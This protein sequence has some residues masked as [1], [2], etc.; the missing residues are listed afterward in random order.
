MRSSSVEQEEEEEE[1]EWRWYL[2]SLANLS[3][4]ISVVV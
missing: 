1:E 4:L 2:S 3:S